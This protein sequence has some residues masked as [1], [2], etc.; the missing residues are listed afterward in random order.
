MLRSRKAAD[1]ERRG[2]NHT[3][4]SPY[5]ATMAKTCHSADCVSARRGRRESTKTSDQNGAPVAAMGSRGPG[6][7][8]RSRRLRR[9]TRCQGSSSVSSRGAEARSAGGTGCEERDITTR[10]GCSDYSPEWLLDW[11]WF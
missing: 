10:L 4:V 6:S 8:K 9:K 7:K 2:A 3:V 11:A 1:C 5:V